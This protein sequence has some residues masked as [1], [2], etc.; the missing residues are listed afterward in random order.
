MRFAGGGFSQ[1]RLGSTAGAATR[2]RA[3]ARRALLALAAVALAFLPLRAAAQAGGGAVVAGQVLAADGGEP[4][5]FS[6]VALI[7]SDTTIP[8]RAVLTDFVGRFAFAAVAPGEYRLRVDRIGYEPEP[9][10]PIRVRAGDALDLLLRSAPHPILLA[11]ITVPSQPCLMEEDLVLEPRLAALWREARKAGDARRLFDESYRYRVQVRER[12]EVGQGIWDMKILGGGR[13][14]VSTPDGVRALALHGPGLGY[15][16]GDQTPTTLYAPELPELLGPGFT[17]THC[18][19]LL[20][21]RGKDHRILFRPSHGDSS[22][23]D[24]AGTIVLGR[25][26]QVKRIEL[27]YLRGGLAFAWGE[28]EYGN[29]RVLRSK[30]PFAQRLQVQTVRWG[31]KGREPAEP[32]TAASGLRLPAQRGTVWLEPGDFVRDTATHH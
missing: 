26:F 23:I 13:V 20:P 12:L 2:R 3:A 29:V 30:L 1:V 17:R 31:R 21:D 27:E 15:G 11:A 5:R 10:P 18:L 7:P 16:A 19:G 24:L 9:L 4:I 32:S 22:R 8:P 28:I 6:L 25:D 14:V